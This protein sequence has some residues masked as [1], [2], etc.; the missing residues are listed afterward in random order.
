MIYS[1]ILLI[2]TELFKLTSYLFFFNL[3]VFISL[4]STEYNF[5]TN[6]N[7]YQEKKYFVFPLLF[8]LTE[9]D[10]CSFG[11]LTPFKLCCSS[12]S[13]RDDA[14]APLLKRFA[15]FDYFSSKLN[16]L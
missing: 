15:S 5:E 7:F 14:I 12:N 3:S 6:T 11:N 4:I 10:Y 8:M 2:S 13:K 16:W 1:L 9:A